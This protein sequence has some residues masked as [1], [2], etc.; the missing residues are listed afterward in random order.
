MIN[1]VQQ[2]DNEINKESL[3]L[4]KINYD[5]LIFLKKKDKIN[6]RDIQVS[7]KLDKE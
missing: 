4:S 6:L 1:R 2:N 3:N 5:V 7:N